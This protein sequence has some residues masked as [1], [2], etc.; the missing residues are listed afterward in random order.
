MKNLILILL[1]AMF[2]NL[3]VSGTKKRTGFN[4]V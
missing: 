1:V 4:F 3:S 2:V